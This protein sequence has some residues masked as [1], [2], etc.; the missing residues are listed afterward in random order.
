MAVPLNKPVVLL[1]V[2]D[3]H[4]SDDTSL[5]FLHY[6]ARRWDEYLPLETPPCTLAKGE[7]RWHILALM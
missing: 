4:W 1:I 6:L 3:L 2:E 5:E 7:E